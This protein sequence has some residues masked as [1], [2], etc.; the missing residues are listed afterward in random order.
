MSDS[1][2]INNSILYTIDEFVL[3]GRCT[4]T[5]NSS[6][7]PGTRTSK[8]NYTLTALKKLD[9]FNTITNEL[10]EKYK[11]KLNTYNDIIL[12]K[13]DASDCSFNF[14]TNTLT[15][16]ENEHLIVSS[17]AFVDVDRIVNYG[18]IHN[19]GYITGSQCLNYGFIYN[20][21]TFEI[22]GTTTYIISDNS[23][24]KSLFYNQENASFCNFNYALFENIEITQNSF[25][26]S[27]Q[28]RYS[29]D[30]YTI[31]YTEI[32]DCSFINQENGIINIENSFNLVNT[33]FINHNIIIQQPGS[34]LDV[35]NG[36]IQQ[37]FAHICEGKMRFQ[38]GAKHISRIYIRY[39]EDTIY[40]QYSR[41]IE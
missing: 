30:K 32:K 11:T 17:H 25:F 10:A 35:T 8:S 19:A 6:F 1:T 40:S 12:E 18:T 28:N 22:K 9:V 37:H 5:D 24:L 21:G 15:V 27:K 41:N 38:N 13:V 16:Y 7:N 39:D 33:E 20:H 26:D 3:L 2:N 29:S 36:T 34:M 23:N 14:Q 31:P 4:K